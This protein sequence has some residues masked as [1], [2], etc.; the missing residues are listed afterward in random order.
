[1]PKLNL[2]QFIIAIQEKSDIYLTDSYGY[3]SVLDYDCVNWVQF[4]IGLTKDVVKNKLYKTMEKY[5]K[6]CGFSNIAVSL[7]G[8]VDSWLS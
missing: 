8:G 7:S 4:A 3:D 1:M 5:F 2:K 6:N